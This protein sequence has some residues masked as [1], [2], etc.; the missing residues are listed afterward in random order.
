MKVVHFNTFEGGGGAAKASLALH[1]AMLELDV[2]ATL[3]VHRKNSSDATV[4][5]LPP[6]QLGFLKKRLVPWVLSAIHH[7][8]YRPMEKWTFGLFGNRSITQ[9][10]KVRKA[11]I[12]SLSWVSWFLDVEA[13]GQLLKQNKPVVWTFYDMWAFT[14]GC[15]YSGECRRFTSQCGNCPQLR[16]SK[17]RDISK[18]LW[19]KKKHAWDT[20]NL[21]IVCPSPWLAEDVR[22]SGLLAGVRVEIIPTG[23]DDSLFKPQSKPDARSSLGLP[24]DK[25]LILFIATRGFANER[26]GGR[27]LEQSL[28]ALSEI[29]SGAFPDV[30]VL[31]RK[32]GVSSLSDKYIIHSR[33]FNDD[34]SLAS[35]YVACDVLVAPSKADTLPLTVLQ[36]MACG[37]PCVA[38]GIGGMGDVIE[39]M[40]NGYLAQP[41][42]VMD[43]AKGIDF[44]L[45]DSL[46]H[47][48][49]SAESI[50]KIHTGF[51]AKHEAE[52]YLKLY[53]ELLS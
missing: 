53:K 45:S 32:Q 14:G 48:A 19:S 26:K 33:E 12:I 42:D 35:L 40:K 24:Q 49:L 15:H 11:D 18:W 4:V 31:G 29:N 28:Q 23:I 51:T 38:Y 5:G 22:K 8:L 50:D 9:H 25:K 39:H 34:V 13:I 37:T 1:R 7:V 43:F 52:H 20:A 36:S 21:T 10:R 27:L 17:E 44:V 41:F 30:V 2:D 3:V 47:D 6:S 46:R 16:S